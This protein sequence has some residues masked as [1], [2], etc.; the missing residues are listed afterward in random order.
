MARTGF[1]REPCPSG[2][3]H[4]PSTGGFVVCGTD[5][6]YGRFRVDR[7]RQ[8]ID[9]DVVE[10]RCFG[11]QLAETEA[12]L[13]HEIIGQRVDK[14]AVDIVADHTAFDD[15]GDVAGGSA[16]QWVFQRRPAV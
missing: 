13:A 12:A 1:Q 11:V 10:H 4:I 2:N 5:A 6:R 9:P 16:A 7:R 8:G 3:S 14:R 15:D